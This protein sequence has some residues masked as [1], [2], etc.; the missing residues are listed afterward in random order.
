MRLWT[1]GD[2]F[3]VP[4]SFT[5]LSLTSHCLESACPNWPEHVRAALGFVFLSGPIHGLLV[6]LVHQFLVSWPQK[7]AC[8][9]QLG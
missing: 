7:G 9:P 2:A 5:F 4:V 6:G 8:V 3:P 1:V